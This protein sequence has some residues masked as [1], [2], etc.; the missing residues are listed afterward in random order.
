MEAMTK[1]FEDRINQINDVWHLNNIVKIYEKILVWICETNKPVIQTQI[2]LTKAR[3]EKL[4]VLPPQPLTRYEI[5]QKLQSTKSIQTIGELR[6]VM[7]DELID[8]QERKENPERI[9]DLK[10]L[11]WMAREKLHYILNN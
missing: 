3:I 11:L 10:Y 1:S 4:W 5:E 8:L 6:T 2:D 7:F 9:Q